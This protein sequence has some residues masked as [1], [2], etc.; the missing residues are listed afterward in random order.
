MT[1][2]HDIAAPSEQ[3]RALASVRDVVMGH[4]A[5]HTLGN[6]EA[7]IRAYEEFLPEL[8]QQLWSSGCEPALLERYQ[9]AH[10]QMEQLR[11]ELG[12]EQGE[13]TRHKIMVVVS[14][15]D[16]PQL[17]EDCLTSL[18]RL[19][20]LFQY[21]GLRHGRYPKVAMFI[22]DDSR[23]ETCIARHRELA[24]GCAERGVE[25]HYFGAREQLECLD[26]LPAEAQERLKRIIGEH[27]L[28]TFYH[29][30]ASAMRNISYLKLRELWRSATEPLLFHF[31]DSDQEFRVKVDSPAG[32]RDLYAI[33]YFHALDRLFSRSDALVV[34]G[35][36]VGDPPVS[37]SVMASGFLDDLIAFVHGIAETD[38]SG[39]CCFHAAPASDV[40]SG[41]AYHDMP[42][43]FGFAPVRSSF[44]YTCDIAGPHSNGDCLNHFTAGLNR[45]F[46][47]EH[48]TRKTRY[49]YAGPGLGKAPARTVYSGNYI[50]RPEGLRYFLPF[51]PLRLRMP[52][53][54]L[55]R[56]LQAEL[57][58]RFVTANLPMLHQ[59]TV[60]NRGGMEFRPGVDSAH[61]RV[62]ISGEFVRQ[63]FGDVMLFSVE[64]LTSMGYP[65]A[66]VSETTIIEVLDTTRAALL[67]GY[68]KRQEA[69]SQKLAHLKA[70]LDGAEAWWNKTANQPLS[71][72][73]DIES[74]IADVDHNFGPASTAYAE[75]NDFNCWSRRR[76]ELAKAIAAYGDDRMFW[77]GL[78]FGE[79]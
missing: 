5:G 72:I 9:S 75:I 49:S 27:D 63:F 43:L 62:E 37:P 15:A 51:A 8:E 7:L 24:N 33:S 32:D 20:E 70:E 41:A 73:V 14:V 17:L 77:E 47:G 12:A 29:K 68:N 48:P 50:V 76:T 79:G 40:E 16:R 25:T 1:A 39:A 45:F 31:I 69:I 64:R 18:V 23:D 36:V 26:A 52:G 34:T 28:A 42:E 58:A 6:R 30:G 56:I 13:D 59:R 44:A 11:T 71:A 3:Q 57:A 10:R 22:A 55:G 46:Y 65:E 74:F 35:K 21:G 54:T 53:P 66:T 67:E 2:P 78:L 61:E 60:G 19:C 4:A 38:P